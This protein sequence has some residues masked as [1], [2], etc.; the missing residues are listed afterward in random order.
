MTLIMFFEFLIGLTDIYIAGRIGK[1]VQATYGFAVQLYL[2]FII[3]ANAL[4]VGTVS[5][6]SRLFT[7]ENKEELN[8]AVFSSFVAA[9]IAG[10]AAFAGRPLSD[11][12]S[13]QPPQH[14]RRTQTH[15]CPHDE[16]LCRRPPVPLCADQFEWD[17][18]GPATGSRI[19]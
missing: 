19:P 9:A 1:E 13:H 4:T 15:G 5:V 2:I 8:R 11:P 3:L 10:A 16:N 14:P 7:S 17:I 12:G 18:D 6:V